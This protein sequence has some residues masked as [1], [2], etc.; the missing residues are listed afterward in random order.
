MRGDRVLEHVEVSLFRRQLGLLSVALYNLVQGDAGDRGAAIAGEHVGRLEAAG[1]QP[2]LDSLQL[3][4]LH[5]MLAAEGS[6]QPVNP[7]LQAPEVQVRGLEQS[8]L[9]RPQAVPVRGEQN[10]VVDRKSTRLN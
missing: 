4:R 2:G 6:F 3:V 9:G 5:E 8:D 7:E 10:G 1:P